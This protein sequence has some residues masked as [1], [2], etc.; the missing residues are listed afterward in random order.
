MNFYDHTVHYGE[1]FAERTGEPEQFDAALGRVVESFSY[2]ESNLK[3]LIV[4]LLGVPNDIGQIVTAE[5][6]FKGLVHMASSLFKHKHDQ[7]EFVVENEDTEARFSELAGLCF[8]A[9][10][11]RNKIV[12]SSYVLRRFRIKTTAKTKGGLKTTVDAI[13]ADKLLDISDFIGSIG[14]HVLEL[15]MFLGMATRA[16]TTS[17][18]VHYYNGERLIAEFGRDLREDIR[19]TSGDGTP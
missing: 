18:F 2:L 8:S 13:D 15:P 16:S 12:H 6:S 4:L 11:H 1:S 19:V 9:E 7:G 14:T 5:L 10:E 3:N 17:G